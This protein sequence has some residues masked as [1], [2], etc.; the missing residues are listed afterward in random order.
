VT[1]F[2]RT[3]WRSRSA[4]RS[5]DS[6]SLATGVA[7]V[8]ALAAFDPDTAEH[9]ATV[10]VYSRDV[11][12]QLGADAD[13]AA[14]IQLGALVHDVGKLALPAELLLKADP[15]DDDEW[16]LIREHPEAGA[17]IVGGLPSSH[18]LHTIVRHHHE[19]VDGRGYPA[20]LRGSEIPAAARIVGACDAYAAMTQPRP[21]RASLAPGEAIA[22][23]RRNADAQFDAEVVTALVHVL[24]SRDEDYRLARTEHFSA[25]HQHAELAERAEAPRHAAAS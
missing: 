14:A 18:T 13:S 25:E 5:V 6:A 7:L 11:A 4:A 19:R 15:L 8:R 3:P 17:R 20:G 22:E 9:S 10:A 23:L 1:R 24:D 21:Y 16:A 12:L 2:L